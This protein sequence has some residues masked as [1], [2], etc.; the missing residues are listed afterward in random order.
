MTH[1]KHTKLARPSTGHWGR[2]EWAIHG[3]VCGNIQS[4]AHELGARLCGRWKT[5]YVDADHKSGVE[6]T[7]HFPFAIRW[8]DKIGFHRLDLSDTPNVWEQRFLL[9]D[10]DLVLI[11]GNHFEATRQILALDRRKFDSLSRKLDRLTHVGALLIKRDDPDFVAPGEMPEFLKNHLPEWSMLPVMD[12]A[13][14]DTIAAFL[15]KNI[16][17]APLKA[18][19]LAG[20]KSARMGQD[21][22]EIAYYGQPQ[23][24]YLRSLIEKNGL[25]VFISCREEQAG[26]FAG[27][28]LIADTFIGLGPFGAIL[29]AFRHHPDAAWL[30][31]A[32]DLPLLDEAT[33][34]YLLRHRNPVAVATAFRQV[35]ALPGFSDTAAEETGFPEPL[36]AIWE[37]KSYG[38]LL[39][40]LSQGISCPRKVL[41]NSGISLLDAPDPSALV[42]VNTPE[43]QA[44][45]LKKYL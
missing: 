29:S 22:A 45:I 33:I 21:K 25:E 15:E 41:I 10:L 40:F 34:G 37:P 2:Q 26:I 35:P 9:N 4:L 23:W 3:T 11:N 30:V 14:P 42:N 19:I 7:G 13:E 16:K 6:S 20:G 17:V 24:Q 38:R 32:C 43:E 18:L 1:Q 5:G 12:M 39:Q 36:I 27:Q 31:V 28:Q 8:T 44:I